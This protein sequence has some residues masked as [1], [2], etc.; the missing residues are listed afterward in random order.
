MLTSTTYKCAVLLRTLS[1]TNGLI[2][3]KCGINSATQLK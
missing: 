2:G 1:P 3:L